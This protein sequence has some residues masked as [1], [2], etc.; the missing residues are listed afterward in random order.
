MR[1]AKIFLKISTKNTSRHSFSFLNISGNFD[2]LNPRTIHMKIPCL[3]LLILLSRTLAAQYYYNDIIATAETNRQMKEYVT[4]KVKAISAAGYDSKN[5]RAGDFSEYHQIL[6]NGRALKI[7]TTRGF[8][9]NI[10]YSRYDEQLRLISL[11][12]SFSVIG[13]TTVYT[14]DEKDRVIKVQNTV[15]DS[16]NDF[17]Q[18]ET[19]HWFYDSNGK[20]EKMWRVVTQTGGEMSTDSLEVIFTRD[21]DGNISEE[22]AYRGGKETYFLYYYYDDKNRLIDIVRY[23]KKLARLI[24]DIMFEYDDRD[25]VIQKITT[26]SDRVI[27]YLI[28]RYVYDEN[29]LKTK[30]YLFNNDKQLTGKIEFTY[31]FGS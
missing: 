2:R 17:N 29:G 9:K 4:K 12:D 10:L 22:R 15:R 13:N 28:W 18:A 19:H 8:D 11:A 16:A 25:R 14:Y 21:E 1:H 6:E 5:T 23:N 7:S 3:I 27:G 20:P 24:P 30:E 31:T 26:T